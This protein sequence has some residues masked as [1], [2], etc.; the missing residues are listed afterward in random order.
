MPAKTTKP[1][2]IDSILKLLGRPNGAT[3]EQL[4]KATGWQPHSVRA[5]LSGLRKK[6]HKVERSTG[7][8]GATTYRILKD[9]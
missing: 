4:R 5:S 1:T 2:K 8:K 7:A 9:A 6:D 3:I